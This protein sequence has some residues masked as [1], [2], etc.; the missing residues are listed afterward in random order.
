[1]SI[2]AGLH[3]LGI[4]LRSHAAGEHKTTCPKCSLGRK[5]KTETCLSV[6]V[7]PGDYALVNCHHCGWTHRV[8]E[9]DDREQ[10]FQRRGTE[11]KTYRQPAY[12][13]KGT[14]P[15]TAIE[16]LCTT[17]KISKEVVRS[18]KIGWDTKRNMLAFPYYF[19]GEVLNI[20]YRK[21]PKDG[22][23][24][25]PDAKLLFYNLDAIVGQETAIITEGEMDALSLITAGFPNVV[26]VPNGAVKNMREGSSAMEYLAHA[27][28]I[29][30]KVKRVIIAVDGD[31]AGKTL[32][33]ELARR[34]GIAKCFQVEYPDGCKDPNDVLINYDI[35]MLC[36]VING[37]K[38][39]PVSGIQDV[40]AA[41]DK[42]LHYYNH[43]QTSGVKTGWSNVD[44]LYTVRP[45]ELTVVTGVPN[46]GKSEWVDALMMNLATNH[47][48]KFAIFSPENPLYIHVSKMIE[49][50]AKKSMGQY[51]YNRM[52]EEELCEAGIKINQFFF[53]LSAEDEEQEETIDWILERARA[54]VLRHGIKGLVIDP[55]NEIE[56]NI[57][58][59]VREDQYISKMLKR[60][61]KF[62]VLNDIHIW[63]VAHP[64][65]PQNVKQGA[66][67]VPTLYD[68]SG[69]AN[70]ANK[71]DAGIVVQ[72]MFEEKRTKVLVKK[73]RFKEVGRPGTAHL[74]YNLATGG[75]CVPDDEMESGPQPHYSETEQRDIGT[76]FG[77]GQDAF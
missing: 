16:W 12:E 13:F 1:M 24:L 6:H 55:Y 53:F 21:P 29:L 17:R 57:P 11:K 52:T 64:A 2:Q 27:E 4:T 63:I 68:I 39:F 10:H 50:Y 42:V 8:L 26:S 23:A 46:S 49:K 38:P 44:N 36:Y 3:D 66:E 31:E 30:K 14:L 51:A 67:F 45:G 28:E 47:G 37:A 9:K 40:Y 41:M 35:D 75:Y 33:Q 76:L 32:E 5:N 56:H 70:W 58:P 73:I 20:K 7:S 65:K 22:F 71:C 69:G 74:Q 43:G 48:W 15:P 18:M 61:K 62:A 19:K 25:E 60:L 77:E 59:G 72:R 54:C 34:I